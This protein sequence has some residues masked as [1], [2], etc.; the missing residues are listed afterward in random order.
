MCSSNLLGCHPQHRTTAKKCWWFNNVGAELPMR[1]QGPSKSSSETR[2]AVVLHVLQTLDSHFLVINSVECIVWA[3]HPSSISHPVNYDVQFTL[4]VVFCLSNTNRL[5]IPWRQNQSPQSS[6]MVTNCRKQ[7]PVPESRWVTERM[8]TRIPYTPNRL[9]PP[10]SSSTQRPRVIG[11][12]NKKSSCIK[13][14]ESS[15]GTKD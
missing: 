11:Y 4:G 7:I 1:T 14:I 3:D 10:C 2:S 13:C 5:H 8:S 15:I 6:T 9:I 12:K